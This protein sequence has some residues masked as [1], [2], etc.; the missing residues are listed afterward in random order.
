MPGKRIFTRIPLKMEA[1]IISNGR[2]LM[3]ETSNLSLYGMF[4]KTGTGEKTD[5]R[6]R[7][8]LKTNCPQPDM[9]IHVDGIIARVAE[10]GI[11][12][13]FQ[14]VGVDE[15]IVLK[16]IVC[17]TYGDEPKIMNEFYSYIDHKFGK[18]LW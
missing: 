12:V 5:S 4:L 1:S 8:T 16:K 15:F 6:V 18:H 2:V 3:G 9:A 10:D 7:V 17:D 11:G 13:R 14:D